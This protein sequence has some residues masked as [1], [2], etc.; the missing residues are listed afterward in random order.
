MKTALSFILTLFIIITCTVSCEKNPENGNPGNSNPEIVEPEIIPV[1][2]CDLVEINEEEY[3]TM[4]VEPER[5]H[6]DSTFLL[7]IENHTQEDLSGGLYYSL[8]YFNGMSWKPINLNV[9]FPMI[10]YYWFSG[11]TDETKINLSRS[12]IYATGKHRIK[13]MV[14]KHILYAEFEIIKEV[15]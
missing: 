15:N 3:L 14:G 7:I 1:N 8:E 12:D 10:L 13:K 6:K 11:K 5:F 4:C 2:S 9:M